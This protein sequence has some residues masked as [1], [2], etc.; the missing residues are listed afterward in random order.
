MPALA[1]T[2]VG[3]GSDHAEHRPDGQPIATGR[4]VAFLLTGI[5][6]LTWTQQ[7]TPVSIAVTRSIPV[8]DVGEPISLSPR[9]SRDT[10][11][12]EKPTDSDS[13]Y[14]GHRRL[15]SSRTPLAVPGHQVGSSRLI[16]V[17]P[18]SAL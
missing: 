16:G 18:P 12:V 1:M 13:R 9:E 11:D 2:W 10:H 3:D 8:E 6:L 4:D 14:H 17:L 5:P 7:R 15:L